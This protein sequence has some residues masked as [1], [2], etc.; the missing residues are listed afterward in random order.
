MQTSSP[1][2]PVVIYGAKTDFEPRVFRILNLGAAAPVTACAS[3]PSAIWFKRGE[4]RCFC[5]IMKFETWTGVGNP[6]TACDEREGSLA[7]LAER[8]KMPLR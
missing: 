5:N 4:L 8:A 1:T 7:R 2:S 6:I 3:C